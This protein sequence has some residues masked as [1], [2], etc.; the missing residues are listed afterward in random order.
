MHDATPVCTE[1]IEEQLRLRP[2]VRVEV[3]SGYASLARDFPRQVSVP[4]K[5]P[6]PDAGPSELNFH[7]RSRRRISQRRIM[8]EHANAEIKQW[9]SLQRWTGDREDLPVIAAIGALVPDRSAKRST[10][11]EPSTKLVLVNATAW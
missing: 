5:K 2:N 1:G 6:A 7:A 3:D 4:P 11:R 8:V 9:P 10:R